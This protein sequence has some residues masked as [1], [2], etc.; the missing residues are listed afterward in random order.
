MVVMPAVGSA[1]FQ[2]NNQKG[3]DNGKRIIYTHSS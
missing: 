3:I 1:K 2:K